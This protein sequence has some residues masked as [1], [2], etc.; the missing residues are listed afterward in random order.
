M[1]LSGTFLKIITC[2]YTVSYPG[3]KHRYQ[4]VILKL[5][6]WPYFETET[7]FENVQK[8]SILLTDMQ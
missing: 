1:L 4:D 8:V 5:F 3:H 2:L 7:C 6:H